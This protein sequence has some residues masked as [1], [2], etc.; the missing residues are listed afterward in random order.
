MPLNPPPTIPL[1]LRSF[2]DLRRVSIYGW[3]NDFWY[4][5][6]EVLRKLLLLHRHANNH[7]FDWCAGCLAG[8]RTIRPPPELLHPLV[9]GCVRY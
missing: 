5:Y 6:G 8:I 7:K 4:I 9:K 1:V 2:F 3:V